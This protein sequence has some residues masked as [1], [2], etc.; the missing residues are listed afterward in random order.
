MIALMPWL[1]GFARQSASGGVVKVALLSIG[2]GNALLSRRPGRPSWSMP[3]VN[4]GG[5]PALVRQPVFAPRGP[6]R[7]RYHLPQPRRLR[8]HQ[9][10]RRRL[11]RGRRSRGRHQPVLPAPCRRK[12][13]LP[14]T[15]A[16]AR[17]VWPSPR[18]HT[19]GETLT[20]DPAPA[21]AR[22]QVLWPP[23]QC[24]MNSN[25]AGMVLRLTFGADRSFSPPTFRTRPCASCSIAGKAQVGRSGR[26]PSRQQR[27]PDA[28]FVAAVNPSVIVSS[29]AARLTKKQRDF[30]TMIDHRPLYRTSRCGEIE[31]TLQRN[32]RVTVKPFIEG[33]SMN[34]SLRPMER[35]GKKDEHSHPP[36]YTSPWSCD[37]W[38]SV[39]R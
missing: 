12:R 23:K 24:D 26:P 5:S 9:R 1:L 17:S 30:E 21:G 10:R 35:C 19:A 34:W 6:R 22:L 18:E 27:V 8:P 3:V 4:V 7:H 31:I 25:N 16:T 15:A 37:R 29:N 14:A 13:P 36:P 39:T 11:E 28:R 38:N 2:A 20:I 33:S 32:G